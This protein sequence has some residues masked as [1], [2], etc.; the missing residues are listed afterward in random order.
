MGT[1]DPDKGRMTILNISDEDVRGGNVAHLVNLLTEISSTPKD[2]KRLRGRLVL[3]FP[4]FD[5]DP[6]PNYQIP[7]IRAFMR[8][9][10]AGVPHAPY[11]FVQDPSLGFIQLYLLALTDGVA[12][13]SGAIMPADYLATLTA[14]ART[15]REFCHRIFDEPEDTVEGLVLSLPTAIA[16]QIPKL[17]K[18]VLRAMR[19]VL[20]ALRKDLASG[21]EAVAAGVTSEQAKAFRDGILDRAAALSGIMRSTTTGGDLEFLDSV[22]AAI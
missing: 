8:A 20:E 5:A 19:P 1:A 9:L 6:R 21:G 17:R 22:L 7:E 12:D 11:F 15:I 4:S 14:K 16:M 18:E 13:G 10:D 3:G 2:A